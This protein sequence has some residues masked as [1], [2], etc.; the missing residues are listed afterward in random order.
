MPATDEQS[1]HSSGAATGNGSAAICAMRPDGST[2]ASIDQNSMIM[3][4]AAPTAPL[5]LPVAPWPG[6][7][8]GAPAAAA[9]PMIGSLGPLPNDATPMP[10]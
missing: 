9:A 10:A 5:M 6:N 3:R 7:D 8:P 4:P 1:T 2:R